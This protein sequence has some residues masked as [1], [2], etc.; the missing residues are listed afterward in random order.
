MSVLSLSDR[1]SRE[2]DVV[3]Q[4]ESTSLA[5]YR[6][7]LDPFDQLARDISSKMYQSL[8]CLSEQENARC[9]NIMARENFTLRDIVKYGFIGLGHAMDPLLVWR[10]QTL[11][12]RDW[13]E[14]VKSTH[15][16]TDIQ[17]AVSRGVRVLA[18]LSCPPEWPLLDSHLPSYANGI[19]NTITLKT[20]SFLSAILANAI[21]ID[22]SPESMVAFDAQSQ[23]WLLGKDDDDSDGQGGDLLVGRTRHYNNI[24]PDLAPTAVQL[25]MPHHPC[26][27]V[28]PWPSFRSKAIVASCTNPPTI[29][30]D[31]LC[32]DMMS[33]GVQCWGTTM[34]SMN[35]RGNGMPWDSRSWMA[36]P[37]FLKKWK[38]LTGDDHSDISR[39]SAWWRSMQGV[40]IR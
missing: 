25:S 39:T 4:I 36:M 9:L 1:T 33:G 6:P 26:F 29:D 40:S 16:E 17:L 34:G 2:Q 15:K 14:L 8:M 10:G 5:L 38:L 37:W 22:I 3:S 27:D 24:A 18:Q 30:E 7:E 11:S 21:H 28:L 31:D 35:G 23:F 19:P 20:M 12:F 13:I 32:L